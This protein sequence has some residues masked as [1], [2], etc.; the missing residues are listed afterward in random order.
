[1]ETSRKVPRATGAAPGLFK[2]PLIL[3]LDD[4]PMSIFL[5]IIFRSK[6]NALALTE[7]FD[8]LTLAK[9]SCTGMTTDKPFPL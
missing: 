5:S 7:A 1:M 3:L 9:K 2:F 4:Q 8:A 6:F